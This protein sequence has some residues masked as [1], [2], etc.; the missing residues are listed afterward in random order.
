MP[1]GGFVT[2]YTDITAHKQAEH[3][4]R[5]SEQRF[6]SLYDDNPSMFFTLDTAGQILSVNRYGANQLGY[7][8]DELVGMRI[9]DLSPKTERA[10]IKEYLDNCLADPEQINR[11]QIIKNRKDGSRMWVREV[12]RVVV[13][14]DGHTRIMTV[15]EDVTVA[16]KLSD[17]LSHQASHDG[18]TGLVNRWSFEQ[19][20]EQV[21]EKNR[22]SPQE[23]AIL[24]V[25]LDRFK[26]INDTCG[27]AAGDEFLRQM[28][29]VLPGCVRKNDT[30]ARIGGDEFGVLLEGCPLQQ[31]QRVAEDIRKA[32]EE[33]RFAWEE[34]VF[35]V[36][37]SIGVVEISE[38]EQSL[39][40]VLAAADSAC[41]VAKDGGRN[42]VHVFH[43]EDSVLAARKGEMQWL[44]RTQEA[45]NEDR[46]C[47]YYQTIEPA[48]D[49]AHELHYEVLLSMLDSH[50]EIIA[51]GAFLPSAERYNLMP[52]LDRWVINKTLSLLGSH[53]NHL[54]ELSVCSINLSGQSLTDEGFDDFVIEC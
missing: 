39:S 26:I 48:P 3:A 46:F 44:T 19:R 14:E 22:I 6:K 35:S 23:H 18:L 51:P 45:L 29:G 49:S 53:P 30:V 13:N 27:H 42:R 17:Q 47:L 24:F 25:D 38:K 1:G 32:I 37:A 12:A 16:R 28:G 31:A 15:C 36:G 52:C 10:Q 41:Y 7:P 33:F 34:Q 40:A 8:L 50:G 21:L 9:M 54:E 43:E 11:W 20:V 4:L 5:E 2:T